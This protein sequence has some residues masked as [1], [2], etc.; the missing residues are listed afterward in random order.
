MHG[1]AQA[2]IVISLRPLLVAAYSD[3]FDAVVILD[4]P[5]WLTPAYQLQPGTRLLT[6]CMYSDDND[7]QGDI[8]PGPSCTR[9]HQI[10]MPIVADFASADYGRIRQLK[11]KITEDTWHKAWYLGLTYRRTTARLGTF[12][13]AG[14][15][16]GRCPTACSW[17]ES[18]YVYL[19][20]RLDRSLPR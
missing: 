14:S 17:H 7:V 11:E 16:D 2:G 9:R 12:W 10:F 4:M 15:V 18:K 1:D 5:D 3:E 6:C 19:R 8:I 13:I 20:T